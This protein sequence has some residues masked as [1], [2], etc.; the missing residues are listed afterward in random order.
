MENK[1]KNIQLA[2]AFIITFGIVLVSISLA[3]LITSS[4]DQ[5]EPLPQVKQTYTVE[6]YGK[7]YVTDGLFRTGGG[8]CAFEVNDKTIYI[9]GQVVATEN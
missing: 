3:F 1:L 8:Y 6:A 4:T 5:P 2:L 9:F 7:T